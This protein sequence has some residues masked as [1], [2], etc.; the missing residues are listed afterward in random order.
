MSVEIGDKKAVKLYFFLPLVLMLLS[1]SCAAAESVVVTVAPPV[2]VVERGGITGAGWAVV[3]GNATAQ[4]VSL[5]YPNHPDDFGGSAGTGTAHSAD[6]ANT[7]TPGPDDWPIAQAV[8]LWQDR[9]RDGRLVACGIHWAPDPKRRGEQTAADV[10]ADAYRIAISTDEGRTWSTAGATLHCPPEVGIIARPLP[11]IF[12]DGKGAW[13]MPA[14]SGS[15][16]GNRALLLRSEDRGRNWSVLSSVA[17]TSAM[18]K[19]GAAPTTPWLETAVARTSDGSLL[20]VMR[21]GSSEHAALVAARSDDDG[22]TWSAPEKVLA[23]SERRVVTGKLPNLLVMPGGVLVLQTAHTK[24]GCVLHV[25]SDGTG[26]QWSEAQIVTTVSGGNTS[27][28]ALDADTLLV[29]T[30]SSKRISCWKVTIPSALG[31]RK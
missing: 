3:V 27:L 8:A 23:G 31:N 20:A 13:L 11:H 24:I 30:P 7:W 6:G 29:F 25:S 1:M 14:Y 26:R 22:R 5:I 17:T 2:T 4:R 10:P 16:T 15:K 21:T 9:L 12:E 19:A 28:T 18:V